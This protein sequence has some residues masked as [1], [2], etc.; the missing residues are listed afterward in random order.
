MPRKGTSQKQ[1]TT[2]SGVIIDNGTSN[3]DSYDDGDYDKTK[4]R[5][6]QR[7]EEELEEWMDNARSP[8]TGDDEKR[9]SRSGNE[10]SSERP[11]KKKKVPSIKTPKNSVEMNLPGVDG[12]DNI[13]NSF[14]SRQS[15][16]RVVRYASKLGNKAAARD[17]QDFASPSDLSRVSTLPPTPF[18][19]TTQEDDEEDQVEDG[20]EQGAADDVEEA[21]VD[22]DG[23]G[24]DVE[25]VAKS[26]ADAQVHGS[27]RSLNPESPRDDFPT[28][29]DY[30]DDDYVDYRN[31]GDDLG[32]P[33][34][35]DDTTDDENSRLNTSEENEGSGEGINGLDSD[36]EDGEDFGEEDKEGP[37]FNMVHDPE[38]PHS[39]RRQRAQ[40]EREGILQARKEDDAGTGDD[41][42]ED[43]E[44]NDLSE[45][46]RSKTKETKK[47]K[48]KTKKVTMQR[49]GPFSPKGIPGPRTYEQ[50]P[51]H[52]LPSP[53][54]EGPRRSKRMKIPPL[55]FW[56]NERFAYGANDNPEEMGDMPVVKTIQ[57]A[58]DTPY[59]KR[60]GT[61]NSNNAGRKKNK[62]GKRAPDQDEVEEFD[63]RKLQKKYSIIDGT[64][65]MVWDDQLDQAES[66][67]K[68]YASST[69]IC[70]L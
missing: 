21:L 6:H 50:I 9:A 65:A 28:T 47:R 48:K 56:K 58:E 37:S 57:K 23:E 63:T 62:V 14:G 66:T 27:D 7:D 32:P 52:N 70:A 25:A 3:A 2:R 64:D 35:Q 51:Y 59:K 18:E 19:H 46:K 69:V 68:L 4:K 10:P 38:T 41:K 45:M 33:T 60:K 40:R 11:S 5:Q 42:D 54:P 49:R 15:S 22:N 17:G 20:T 39:V 34:H 24:F 16:G 12:N 30:D 61:N 8:A 31:G 29:A 1:N 55:H 44:S 53:D 67:S 26:S 43:D 36:H 13:E